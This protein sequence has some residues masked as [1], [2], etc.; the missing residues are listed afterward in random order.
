MGKD[1]K[2]R[3]ILRFIIRVLV[4]WS[5]QVVA[6][7]VMAWLLPGVQ[8]DGVGTAV[9]AVGIIALLNAL[10]WPLLSYVLLPFAVLTLGLFSLLLNGA[11]ILLADALVDGFKVNNLGWAIL[12]AL[13]LTAI[14]TILS[15]LLTIDDDS[16]WF[17][18]VVRR[19]ARRRTKVVETDEPGFVFLEFDGLAKPILE[20]AMR[21]GIMPNLARWLETGSHRLVGWEPD[22]SSQTSASQAGILLGNNHNIPA[23]RWYDRATKEIRT[24]GDPKFLASLE[25]T[26]SSGK[27]LLVDGGASRGNMFSGDASDVMTT[28]STI[29]DR[30]RFHT[31][32]FQAY[33]LNPYHFSRTLLLAIWDI[34]LEIWQFRKARHNHAYPIMDRE[35]RGGIYPLV[36][37]FNT[38]I[39]RDLNVDTLVGDMFGGVPAVYATIVA[40]DEVAHHSGIESDDVFDI[41]H[42]LDKQIPRLERAAR[43]APRP[44]HLVVLSDHGQ[45]EGATFK[46]RY[47]LSLEELIQ[48]LATEKYV[49][50]SDVNVHEDWNQINALLTETVQYGQ[51]AIKKP[52]GSVLK[53]RTEDG[54]VALGPQATARVEAGKPPVEAGKPSVPDAKAPAG[55]EESGEDEPGSHIVVLASGNLGLVYGTRIDR[56]ATMEQIEAFYPGLLDGLAQHEGIGFLLVHSEADGPVVI[57]AEGRTYLQEGR[58]EGADPLANFGP[59]AA[60]HLRRNDSFPDAPDIYVSSF[61]DPQTGEGAA[62]EEQIGF[63]GGMGGSQ[64]QPFVLAPSELPLTGEPLIGAEA[65]YRLLKGWVNAGHKG[66]SL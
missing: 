16:V 37:A 65:V 31:V 38:V 54:Q 19:R 51:D 56:R 7:F 6:L 35:H 18:N 36:R 53:S 30:S 17:R 21:Q 60:L 22:M 29:L 27:G 58:M 9:V 14:T 49:V 52:L 8:V 43:E 57:V 3:G 32:D 4:I 50:Q 26:L 62:F 11:F 28:A 66:V 63:H 48:R 5:V 64:T 46:Q 42:K 2:S 25:K 24:S 23:F 33:F 34:V 47:G 12:L 39:M 61:Y 15:S 1:S 45:T 40:Y 41:L 44:Y 10:L 55:P 20:R 59:N 13:G